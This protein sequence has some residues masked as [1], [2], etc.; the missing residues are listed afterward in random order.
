MRPSAVLDTATAHLALGSRPTQPP[1]SASSTLGAGRHVHAREIEQGGGDRDGPHA[2]PPR[3]SRGGAPT[4][5]SG[6]A[7]SKSGPFFTGRSTSASFRGPAQQRNPVVAERSEGLRARAKAHRVTSSPAKSLPPRTTP[8]SFG[9]PRPQRESV[10]SDGP[11]CRSR[12]PR[13]LRQAARCPLG[14]IDDARAGAPA[15]HVCAS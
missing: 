10:H 2:A 7:L 5:K 15:P 14:R 3:A 6:G 13:A 9:P 8:M 11:P 1:E 4:S 12:T